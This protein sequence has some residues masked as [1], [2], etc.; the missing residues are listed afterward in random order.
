MFATPDPNQFP[1]LAP[2]ERIQKI[3]AELGNDLHKTVSTRVGEVTLESTKRGYDV[4]IF[5]C[6]GNDY[7]FN[8]SLDGQGAIVHSVK[9]VALGCLLKNLGEADSQILDR[10]LTHL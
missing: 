1:T 3:A 8:Y 6:G 2:A 10:A 7:F 9:R 5:V 4:S